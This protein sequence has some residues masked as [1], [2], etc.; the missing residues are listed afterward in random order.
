MAI[1]DKDCGCRNRLEPFEPYIVMPDWIPPSTIIP[2]WEQARK[3]GEKSEGKRLPTVCTDRSSISGKIGALFVLPS[4]SESRYL[5]TENEYTVYSAE[6]CGIYEA[7]RAISYTYT[8]IPYQSSNKLYIFTDYQAT[9]QAVQ[10]LVA[11]SGQVGS[12]LKGS[13][14]VSTFSEGKE[15]EW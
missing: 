6:L 10:D 5:G 15:L 1:L 8:G 13:S 12:S 11:I 2:P 9:I 3:I 7:L 4:G 14:N